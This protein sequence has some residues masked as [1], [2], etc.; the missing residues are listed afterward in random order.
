MDTSEAVAAQSA[1]QKEESGSEG[2]EE[3]GG[4][5]PEDSSAS[6][7]ACS[8]ELFSSQEEGSQSQRT[9]LGE[10]QTAEEVPDATLKSQPSLLSTAKRLQRIR[11]RP[12]RTKEDLLHEVIQQSLTENQ[13][14]Q[15]WR[16]TER[17]LR[18]Q[19]AD[20]RHQSTE[21]LISIMERQ[22]DPI[23]ALIALQMEQIPSAALV[24]KLSLVPPVTAN[25][26]PPTSSFILP[27]AASNTCSFTTQP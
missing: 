3:E 26:L 7:D 18:Q 23:Q 21:Q 9:V 11:K 15:E 20:R 17:R 12:R 19:N 10:E 2:A 13:K 4:P 25:P 22:A 16:E 14:V 1:R 6:L 8:Q 24:Q 27:S 5:E